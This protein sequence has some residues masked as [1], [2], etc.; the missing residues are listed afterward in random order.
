MAKFHKGHPRLSKITPPWRGAA[1]EIDGESF[2]VDGNPVDVKANLNEL[3]YAEALAV[4][5]GRYFKAEPKPEPVKPVET[6]NNEPTLTHED[7]DLEAWALG[8]KDAPMALVKE[9]I[10]ERYGIKATN[11]DKCLRALVDA[12]II[13]E[14]QSGL[15]D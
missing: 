4:N 15:L 8:T 12:S 7:I 13:T 11:K 2:D 3:E 10:A 6:P 14:E 5:K 9:A 1:F